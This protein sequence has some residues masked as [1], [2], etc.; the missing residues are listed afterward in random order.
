MALNREELAWAAGF[1]DGEGHAGLT[2]NK[3][4]VL[5][6]ANTDEALLQR[7]HAAVLGLGKLYGPY[8]RHKKN[9]KDYWKWQITNFEHAQAVAALLWSFLGAYKKNRYAEAVE[10]FVTKPHKPTN[11]PKEFCRCGHSMKDARISLDGSRQCR[12]C[13]QAYERAYYKR[14]RERL[15]AQ[16]DASAQRRR[17][18]EKA[19]K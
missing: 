10:V 1:F 5:T 8:S 16:C 12:T 9:H 19:E 14:N 18:R 4:P 2:P 15:R 17:L 6:V 3:V 7:F 11:W 13:K